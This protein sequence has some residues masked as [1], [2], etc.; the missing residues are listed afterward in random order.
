M[1]TYLDGIGNTAHTLPEYKKAALMRQY[2]RV[3]KARDEHRKTSNL[4]NSALLADI[5][6]GLLN[7]IAR[8]KGS[9]VSLPVGT[10][11]N[12]APY[13]MESRENLKAAERDY[14]GLLAKEILFNPPGGVTASNGVPAPTYVPP[15]V[16]K[17]GGFNLPKPS[18]SWN[19]V[20]EKWRREKMI[21]PRWY[22]KQK[23]NYK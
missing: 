18:G 1:A 22:E 9:R 4:H 21:T 14:K 6:S 10:A 16:T 5:A 8:R 11:A 2:E 13:F 12:T 17:N 3:L 19:K 20:L 7:I 23:N 15:V